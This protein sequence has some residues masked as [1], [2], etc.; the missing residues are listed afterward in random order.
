MNQES[1]QSDDELLTLSSTY[2][3]AEG[4]KP[5]RA[6]KSGKK[7]QEPA[8]PPPPEEVDL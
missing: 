4:D 8:V 5:C 1:E 6:K 2:G 7:Q 3:N